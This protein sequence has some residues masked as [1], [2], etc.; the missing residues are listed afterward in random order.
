MLLSLPFF[1]PPGI[2]SFQ[3]KNDW[4]NLIRSTHNQLSE[5]GYRITSNDHDVK[6]FGHEDCVLKIGDAKIGSGPFEPCRRYTTKVDAKPEDWMQ[7]TPWASIGGIDCWHECRNL[8]T[9]SFQQGQS[10][11]FTNVFTIG[12]S[13]SSTSKPGSGLRS[14]KM[15]P[16]NPK[17]LS[18]G[19]HMNSDSNREGAATSGDVLLWVR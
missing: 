4:I 7:C 9:E 1:C 17:G 11:G 15:N 13:H 5:V 19:G 8:V 14:S 3:Y 12:Y 18:Q 10:K 16:K 2:R 6:Y